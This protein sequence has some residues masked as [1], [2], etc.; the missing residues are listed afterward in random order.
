VFNGVT[1]LLGKEEREMVSGNNEK[2]RN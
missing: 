1:D 2:L